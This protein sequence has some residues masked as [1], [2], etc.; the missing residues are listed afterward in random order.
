[1]LEKDKLKIIDEQ[2]NIVFKDEI[3]HMDEEKS[4]K[5]RALM[6]KMTMTGKKVELDESYLKH[7]LSKQVDPDNI[8]L[9]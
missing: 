9:V 5:I 6:S 4:E 7:R 1:M 8:I 3:L 2:G